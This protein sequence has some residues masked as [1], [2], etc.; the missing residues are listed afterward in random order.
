MTRLTCVLFDG[1]RSESVTDRKLEQATYLEFVRREGVSGI[2]PQGQIG[3]EKRG[4]GIRTS[5][6]TARPTS[7]V[8]VLCVC[9]LVIG[10]VLCRGVI[11]RVTPHRSEPV[12]CVYTNVVYEKHEISTCTDLSEKSKRATNSPTCISLGKSSCANV[13]AWKLFDIP[14]FMIKYMGS[15]GMIRCPISLFGLGAMADA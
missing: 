4:G 13:T 2:R 10:N 5:F 1:K 15:S 8:N 14:K 9:I 11:R 12:L 6:K 7:N 3:T